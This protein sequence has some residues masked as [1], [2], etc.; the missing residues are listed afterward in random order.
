MPLLNVTERFWPNDF[1]STTA[2]VGSSD[3][4]T[5]QI[6][7]MVRA[8]ADLPPVDQA[9]LLRALDQQQLRAVVL[10]FAD[11]RFGHYK[12]T[13][14]ETWESWNLSGALYDG[15]CVIARWLYVRPFNVFTEVQLLVNLRP[16]PLQYE[17]GLQAYRVVGDRSRILEREQVQVRLTNANRHEV[18]PRA[19][20]EA[21]IVERSVP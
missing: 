13:K 1:S 7:A 2:P 17:P 10:D 12:F 9:V 5:Q 15:T 19:W 20:L 11:E 21:A 16:V 8:F 14:A 18:R 3:E 6:Q 4:R